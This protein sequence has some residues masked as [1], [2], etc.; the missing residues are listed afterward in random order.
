MLNHD[1]SFAAALYHTI[2]P[3][4]LVWSETGILYLGYKN[5]KKFVL[6]KPE[7][8]IIIED[9]TETENGG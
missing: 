5:F 2:T 3:S 9:K 8:Y 6:T 4:F 1:Y 7:S